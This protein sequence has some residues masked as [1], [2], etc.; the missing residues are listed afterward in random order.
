MLWLGGWGW[1]ANGGRLA[2]TGVLSVG[3]GGLQWVCG[4]VTLWLRWD[5]KIVTLYL[6]GLVAWLR[7][8]WGS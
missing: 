8:G 5:G 3:W 6:R 7:G 2:I 4:S 1:I